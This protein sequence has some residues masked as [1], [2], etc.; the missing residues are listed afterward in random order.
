MSHPDHVARKMRQQSTWRE[1]YE[2]R[3]GRD[4][5]AFT[6][7]DACL[8]LGGAAPLA[9]AAFLWSF[10]ADPASRCQLAEHLHALLRRLRPPAGLDPVEL[11]ALALDEQHA[12]QAQRRD[13]LRALVLGIS[14]KEWDRNWKGLHARL[15]SELDSLASDAWRVARAR[16]DAA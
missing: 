1:P 14:V 2:T 8:A 12:P 5:D 11:V 16:L 13:D 10:N 4:H 6:V 3:G 7:E 9:T 15:L